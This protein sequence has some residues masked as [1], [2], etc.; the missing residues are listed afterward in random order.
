M[1]VTAFALGCLHVFNSH[2]IP[3]QPDT[4]LG[5]NAPRRLV[6]GGRGSKGGG[7]ASLPVGAEALSYLSRLVHDS[8]GLL[9]VR[10]CR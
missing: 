10:G 3:R 2:A 8:F 1:V 4:L 5:V 6:G 7:A 9:W